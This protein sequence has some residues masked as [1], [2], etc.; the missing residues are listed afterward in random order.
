MPWNLN[1][2]NQS[3]AADKSSTEPAKVDC[4]SVKIW[5]ADMS[6]PRFNPALKPKKSHQNSQG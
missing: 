1:C 3:Q 5:E 4:I 6:A 2:L